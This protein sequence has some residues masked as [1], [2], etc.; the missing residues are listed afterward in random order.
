MAR[1]STE[2]SQAEPRDAALTLL[3]GRLVRLAVRLIWNRDDAEEIVQ[4]AFRLSLANGPPADDPRGAAWLWRTVCNHC[5]NHRRRR[6]AEP[7]DAWLDSPAADDPRA[8]MTRAE[9]LTRL[10]GALETLPA[11]QRLALVLR[12]MEQ[13]DYV[14]VAEIMDL[15]ESAV[16]AHVHLGR[17]RLAELLAE[18]RP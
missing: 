7:L 10:R 2:P 9:E 6:R 11:Q 14:R 8:A 17:R 5:L 3:H 13:L 4:E 18:D 15:S 1:G 12:C 16:R